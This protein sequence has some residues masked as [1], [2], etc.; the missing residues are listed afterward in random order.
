MDVSSGKRKS[1]RPPTNERG[2]LEA[3]KEIERIGFGQLAPVERQPAAE[4]HRRFQAL[5]TQR[6]DGRPATKVHTEEAEPVAIHIRAAH[7]VINRAAEIFG[8][9]NHPVA[10][11]VG[12]G[13]WRG[14]GQ[15]STAGSRS[16][17][18]VR[19][20]ERSFRAAA[21]PSIKPT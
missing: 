2:D 18:A 15:C 8:F 5:L 7:Q 12:A 17:S 13:G 16:R 10:F 20:A 6:E 11:R 9:E 14:T 1:N 3:G 4:E 21:V 19:K